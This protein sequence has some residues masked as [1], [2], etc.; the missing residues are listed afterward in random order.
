MMTSNMNCTVFRG[1][2][3]ACLDVNL[4]NIQLILNSFTLP[5]RPGSV[6]IYLILFFDS[7]MCRKRCVLVCQVTRVLV[8]AWLLLVLVPRC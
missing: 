1:V 7:D 2:R 3:E 5:P 8:R 6:I 4:V